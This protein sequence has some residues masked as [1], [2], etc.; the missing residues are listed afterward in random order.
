MSNEIVL[1]NSGCSVIKA[2]PIVDGTP[3]NGLLLIVD[4]DGFHSQTCIHESD[5]PAFKKFITDLYP[6]QKPDAG[7]SSF[8]SEEEIK[9]I[10]ALGHKASPAQ[11]QALINQIRGLES[12]ASDLDCELSAVMQ[13]AVE[14]WEDEGEGEG[15]NPAT[16]AANAREKALKAIG[17]EAARADALQV[18]LNRAQQASAIRLTIAEVNVEIQIWQRE[19]IESKSPEAFIESNLRMIFEKC[20]WEFATHT[21]SPILLNSGKALIEMQW[22]IESVVMSRQGETGRD[23]LEA[24][25]AYCNLEQALARFKH[26]K[27]VQL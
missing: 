9:S 19:I 1:D 7:Q 11:V 2:G 20:L 26:L 24:R 22:L 25:M 10:E 17:R 4:E 15:L 3:F 18:R 27:K 8:I 5:I 6:D 12:K 23:I 21:I 14:K 16:R 13:L